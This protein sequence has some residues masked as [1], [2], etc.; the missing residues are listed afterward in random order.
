MKV[1]EKPLERRRLNVLEYF[2][3]HGD[4]PGIASPGF[5]QTDHTWQEGEIMDTPHHPMSQEMNWVDYWDS[6]TDQYFVL[7][8]LQELPSVVRP[9]DA[10]GTAAQTPP[11]SRGARE[12][13]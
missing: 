12:P 13:S 7:R 10:G 9:Q 6:L 1:R 11:H 5:L 3:T 8:S 2:P 4:E